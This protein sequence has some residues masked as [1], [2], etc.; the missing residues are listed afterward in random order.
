MLA[1]ITDAFRLASNW[2]EAIKQSA[3]HTYHSVLI[4][5]PTLQPLYKS[6]CEELT[7][8][9]CWLR[10]GPAQWDSLVATV[11]HP[12]DDEDLYSVW[13]SRDSSQ[14]A[15]LAPSDMRFWD[16]MSGTPVSY[17]NLGGDSIVLADDF[18]IAAIPRHDTINLY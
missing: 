16:A 4:F 14:L 18:S 3:L 5:P 12:I 13:F 8:K 11:F 15:S 1:M 7:H 2:Y 10:G 9:T 17:S 6:H